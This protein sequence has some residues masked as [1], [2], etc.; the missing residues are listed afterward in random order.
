[1]FEFY[2]NIVYVKMDDEPELEEEEEKEEAAA[3]VSV[4]EPELSTEGEGDWVTVSEVDVALINEETAS[5]ELKKSSMDVETDDIET[6][7]PLTAESLKASEIV[8]SP[9]KV[10]PPGVKFADMTG[11]E[12]SQLQRYFIE[13]SAVPVPRI[14]C[15]LVI[16][17]CSL[18]VYGKEHVY[19]YLSLLHLQ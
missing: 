14:N 5:T 8:N 17:G 6:A 19:K 1:M 9:V 2:R 15:S 7:I 13:N 11:V 4:V 10:A 12:C 18:F 16:R 3:S